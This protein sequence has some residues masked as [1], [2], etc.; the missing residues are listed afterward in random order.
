MYRS[1]EIKEF[2][3]LVKNKFEV[4][5]SLFLNLPYS[6]IR[7][8]GMFIPLL[9][10]LCKS[11]LEDGKEPQEILDNFFKVHA[12]ISTEKGK[13]N[14]MFQVIQYV[15]RQIVLYD[16]VE[17][18]AYPAIQKLSNDLS[19]KD[20]INL[21]EDK[22]KPADVS[23]VLSQ[24]SARI[25]L[26]AHPTQFYSHSVLDIINRLRLLI[27]E[28]N[29]N[30]IDLT[31]QQL[32]LT[33]L[34]NFKKPTPFE[35]AK[36]II[37]FLRYVY[38]DS[39]SELYSHIKNILKNDNFDNPDL[40]KIGFWPGG[41]RDGNPFVTSE[42]T[43]NVADELRMSLMKCYYGDLKIIES[44]MTFR[45]V[46]ALISGLRKN[47]YESMFN[48]S[49]EINFEEILTPLSKIKEHIINDYNS[50][51]V[52]LLDDLINKVK[53]FKTHFAVLD[54]RQNHTIHLKLIEEILKKEKIISSS[55]S[56]ITQE[57]LINILLIRMLLLIQI[58]LKIRLLKKPFTTS[59]NYKRYK[60]KM[61]KQAVTGT[62]LATLKIFFRSYLFLRYSDGVG[63]VKKLIL[64]L[65]RYSN[66]W[67]EC[68]ILKVL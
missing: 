23:K 22:I 13:I 16:S 36:N 37:Y 61:V 68:K 34:V 57:E 35:E 64:I 33:S 66:R 60:G 14:F 28:N 54:I 20:F 10:Q 41:D 32:G 27:L 18:A 26:T 8:I 21:L 25:V 6:N 50:L 12:N 3:K 46:E 29:I 9:Q 63:I 17:D 56:D 62:S 24:F 7:N 51:H 2:E 40:I 52:E 59:H 30:E 19:F 53:I 49:K 65:F 31:L 55:L 11:G 43:M 48:P 67:M 44:R 47:L 1:E 4:Y 38:Y 39:V 15:E 45:K 58:V 5:N 42:V